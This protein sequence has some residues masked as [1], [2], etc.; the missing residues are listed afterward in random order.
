MKGPNDPQARL[1]QLVK[2]VAGL[3]AKRVGGGVEAHR[4][5][6]LCAALEHFPGRPEPIL[7][8]PEALRATV[9]AAANGP[10]TTSDT[11]AY[12]QLH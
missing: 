8:E 2:I 9:S 11:P 12:T 3:P 6:A 7:T 5:K 4:S 10:R 1:K